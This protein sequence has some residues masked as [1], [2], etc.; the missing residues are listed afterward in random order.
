[1][2][3]LAYLFPYVTWF[4]VS[5]LLV[6]QTWLEARFR[7]YTFIII[8]LIIAAALELV[9]N[10]WLNVS[11]EMTRARWIAY[12][13]ANALLG[14]PLSAVVVIAAVPFGFY[15]PFD[16]ED[17]QG[18][19]NWQQYFVLGYGLIWFVANALIIKPVDWKGILLLFGSL[20]IMLITSTVIG[21][22]AA[23]FI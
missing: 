8:S 9:R 6:E 13:V 16:F 19:E 21:I 3:R 17:Q 2:I 5:C 4:I 7:L 12:V 15:G 20:V 1:M 10:K 23:I 14:I 18:Y 11:P 22:I